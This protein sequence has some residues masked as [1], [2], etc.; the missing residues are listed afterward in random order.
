M[1][2][3]FAP[4]VIVVEACPSVSVVALAGFRDALLSPEVMLNDT[5]FPDAA[6]PSSCT[7]TV[8]VNSSPGL[9]D[10]G[11]VTTLIDNPVCGGGLTVAVPLID[12]ES[13]VAVTVYEPDAFSPSV[14]VVEACPL[15]SVVAL[16][17]LRDAFPSP[18]VI[19]K[20]TVFPDAALPS[21]CTSTVNVNSSPGFPVPG[22]VTTLM[23]N[24]VCDTVGLVI[25]APVVVLSIL[26]D[27][28][29]LR[30]ADRLR[31]ESL[32]SRTVK[33]TAAS[34]PPP[35]TPVPFIAVKLAELLVEEDHDVLGLAK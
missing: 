22:L 18:D 9:P 21:S 11:L 35:S 29:S 16:A 2:D 17:G 7:S 25:E 33:V 8:N 4:S 14:I 23:D 10:P 24:P 19:L 1:P 13:T 20:E 34:V 6:V 32:T 5:V 31:V 12:L 15:V 30:L 27:D 3:A 28:E 26:A